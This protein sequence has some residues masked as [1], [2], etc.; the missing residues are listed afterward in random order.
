MMGILRGGVRDVW[1]LRS[2]GCV[3]SVCGK[4]GSIRLGTGVTGMF[5]KGCVERIVGDEG[6]QDQIES[7]TRTGP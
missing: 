3:A 4:L 6:P 7:T 1:V 2:M 5:T